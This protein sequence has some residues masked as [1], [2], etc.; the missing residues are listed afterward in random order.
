MQ[1]WWLNP[2]VG[3]HQATHALLPGASH[4]VH[5]V[6]ATS[7]GQVYHLVRRDGHK[8]LFHNEVML[9]QPHLQP[10]PDAGREMSVHGVAPSPLRERVGVRVR[11]RRCDDDPAAPLGGPLPCPSPELGEGVVPAQRNVAPLPDAGRGWGWG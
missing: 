3:L 8:L 1:K 6:T 7:Y 10:L 4:C 9:D 11:A 5:G 2:S